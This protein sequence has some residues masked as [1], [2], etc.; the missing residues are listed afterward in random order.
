MVPLQVVALLGQHGRDFQDDA[1][2]RQQPRGSLI[3]TLL[4]QT[5]AS[6]AVEHDD[7]APV[8]SVGGAHPQTETLSWHLND[9]AAG[10]VHP[11]QSL[12]RILHEGIVS[13]DQGGVHEVVLARAPVS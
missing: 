9:P 2:G 1:C 4:V 5:I 8:S 6:F 11:D 12:F 10:A 7:A 3:H 13:R